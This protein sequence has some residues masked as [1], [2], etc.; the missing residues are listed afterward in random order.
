ML[1][2]NMYNISLPINQ[3]RQT[4]IY[5]AADTTKGIELN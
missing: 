2:I 1:E 5:K 4:S 3:G